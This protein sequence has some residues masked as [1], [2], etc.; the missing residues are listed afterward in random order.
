VIRR[1]RK[2]RSLPFTSGPLSTRNELQPKTSRVPNNSLPHS[3]VWAAPRQRHRRSETSYTGLAPS[4]NMDVV[5]CMVP[6]TSHL[7]AT[8]LHAPTGYTTSARCVKP[9]DAP[10]P[11]EIKGFRDPQLVG[12][13][14]AG[15][16][17]EVSWPARWGREPVWGLEPKPDYVQAAKGYREWTAAL[18]TIPAAERFTEQPGPHGQ[19]LPASPLTG[20][21]LKIGRQCP[22]ISDPPPGTYWALD[23]RH[24]QQPWTTR[25]SHQMELHTQLAAGKHLKCLAIPT[26]THQ[27]VPSYYARK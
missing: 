8:P 11:D 19:Y 3:T 20:T 4:W 24:P 23:S 25:S 15:I 13:T 12:Q 22:R 18:G 27:G 10:S 26:E 16:P 9:S 6:K 21:F 2:W 1:T 14:A 7:P 17:P 5:E